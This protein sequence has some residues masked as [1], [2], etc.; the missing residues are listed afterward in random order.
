VRI[1]VE[2]DGLADLDAALTTAGKEIRRLPRAFGDIRNRVMRTAAGEA[3]R[4]GGATV[5]SLQGKAS[6][7]KAEVSAG[8]DSR[9]S[10][11]GGVYVAMN[12]YGTRWDGQR[13]NRWLYRALYDSADYGRARLEREVGDKLR[14]AGL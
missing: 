2:F 14:Q 4:Y 13:P 1:E 7:L 9:A 11:G 3:P 8:G 5:G 12:H 6:N 10:H